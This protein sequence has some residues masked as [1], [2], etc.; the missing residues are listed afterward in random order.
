MKAVELSDWYDQYEKNTH[1]INQVKD[2]IKDRTKKVKS[3]HITWDEYS[4]LIDNLSNILKFWT[5][6]TYIGQEKN[7][8]YKKAFQMFFN[9][10]MDF[11]IACKTSENIDL[12]EFATKVL[13]RGMLY[14]YLGYYSSLIDPSTKIEPKYD[15][16]YVSWSKNERNS[17]IE[18]KL[19][20]IMTLLTCE[21][22]EPY[23]GLDLDVFGVVR[24]DE[25][26]VVFPTIENSIIDVKYIDNH[27][28]A[29]YYEGFRQPYSP[30]S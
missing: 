1:A 22:K 15:N 25:K 10:L 20:G 13:Y 18:Q 21:V 3:N 17:Y 5:G 19:K 4:L 29:R 8:R 27:K 26:E 24:G 16:I 12:Q 28:E 30:S 7:S 11:T 23:Y 2:Q 6:H 14:R 9:E